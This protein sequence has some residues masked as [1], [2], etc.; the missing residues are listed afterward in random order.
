MYA[1]HHFKFDISNISTGNIDLKICSVSPPCAVPNSRPI[2]IPIMDSG[3][4]QKLKKI[5]TQ[6]TTI[7]KIN[8]DNISKIEKLNIP[9][10]FKLA[11]T[12]A[13][14]KQKVEPWLELNSNQGNDATKIYLF[15]LSKD[16]TAI[17]IKIKVRNCGGDGTTCIDKE[18]KTIDSISFS[19]S[20]STTDINTII[21]PFEGTYPLDKDTIKEKIKVAESQVK[22]LIIKH[23]ERKIKE[24]EPTIRG[25]VEIEQII[26]YLIKHYNKMLQQPDASGTTLVRQLILC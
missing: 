7:K 26:Y 1:N 4:Q 18:I 2:T 24:L 12:L 19:N 21:T 9:D 14:L 17:D 15:N 20:L 3:K 5:L 22:L 6:F 13:D 10:I 25:K 16:K 11:T 8:D 23:I